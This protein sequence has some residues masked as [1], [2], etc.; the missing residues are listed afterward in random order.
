[1]CEL[2]KIP[3]HFNGHIDLNVTNIY[4]V[5]DFEKINENYEQL[6]PEHELFIETNINNVYPIQPIQMFNF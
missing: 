1:M 5:I 3:S 4:D 6:K 2:F